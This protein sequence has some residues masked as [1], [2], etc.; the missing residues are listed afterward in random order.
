VKYNLR[1]IPIMAIVMRGVLFDDA[2]KFCFWVVLFLC[3]AEPSSPFKAESNV[4]N[5]EASDAST[6]MV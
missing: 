6:V 2:V 3:Y 4:K 1:P 5:V